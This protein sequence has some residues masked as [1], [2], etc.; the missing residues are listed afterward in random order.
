MAEKGSG[1]KAGKV[2][3]KATAKKAARGK[4]R[5]SPGVGIA[6]AAAAVLAL[7]FYALGG[8]T[9]HHGSRRQSA[10]ILENVARL[11][12]RQHQEPVDLNEE[13]R[14]KRLA[15]LQAHKGIL[16]DGERIEGDLLPDFQDGKEHLV[17]VML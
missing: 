6:L 1:G 2:N 10:E 5:Q 3:G 4:K 7:V 16:V 8:L 17:V 15:V 14:L 13:A 9:V 12:A 11:A